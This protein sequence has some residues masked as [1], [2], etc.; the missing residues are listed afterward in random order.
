MCNGS[1]PSEESVAT[2]PKNEDRYVLKNQYLQYINDVSNVDLLSHEETLYYAR[3]ARRGDKSARDTLIGAN[4][5]L[6]VKIARQYSRRTTC[7]HN[8]LDLIEEGNLGLIRAIDKFDPEMGNR[9]STYAVWWIKEFIEASLLNKARTIRL[10]IYVQKEI[11]R[12]HRETQ[13]VAK[14]LNRELAVS[15]I[16]DKTNRSMS[17]IHELI[18]L[19][20][21]MTTVSTVGTDSDPILPPEEY[22]DSKPETIDDLLYHPVLLEKLD[23]LIDLLSEKEKTIVIHRFGLRGEIQ[24]SLGE[25][26][27][28]IGLS[29]ERVRQLQKIALG[30]LRRRFINAGWVF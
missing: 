21:F 7:S 24:K 29:Y 9:L 25:V 23:E 19:S 26:G 27:G 30:K 8:I 2:A 20:G 22:E 5:R 15:D 4:L 12:L 18:E 13:K 16:A 28:L 17:E 11:F 3:R 10:P 1:V 14:E 6:V